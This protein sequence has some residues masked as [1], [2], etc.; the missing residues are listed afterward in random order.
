MN[1]K[2]LKSMAVIAAMGIAGSAY[3]ANVSLT[4]SYLTAPTLNPG[5][6]GSFASGVNP[7]GFTADWFFDL[8][9]VGAG[10][11]LESLAINF[12][13]GLTSIS[14]LT[15]TLYNWSGATQ[16]TAVLG[17]SG[18]SF[19]LPGLPVGDYELVVTGTGGVSGGEYAG[20][21][22]AVPLPAAAWLLVSGLVG[23]GA[24]ARR[25]KVEKLDGAAA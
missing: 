16:G 1:T 2:L 10:G 14:G 4:E 24:M 17:G 9:G 6:L 20:G 22:R 19:T 11:T 25:R 15:M 8:S 13:E 23:V 12:G 7:G 18:T 5:D 3:A 21:V